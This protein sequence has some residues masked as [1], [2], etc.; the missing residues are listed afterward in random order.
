MR[1]PQSSIG[2]DAEIIIEKKRSEIS[3][4]LEVC[5]LN[6]RYLLHA[7]KAN[8]SCGALHIL[9]QKAF[10]YFSIR[11]RKIRKVL[12]LGFGAGSAASIICNDMGLDPHIT[13]IEADPVVIE[14]ARK[15]FQLEK[16]KNLTLVNARAQ[17]FVH[18]SKERFDLI[19]NDVFVEKEV[20]LEIKHEDYIESLVRMT[21]PHGIGFYN[22]IAED[23]IQAE[24]FERIKDCFSNQEINLYQRA[25]STSN[26]ILV[27]EKT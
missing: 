2:F 13:G 6:G 25:F 26:R 17:D 18:T 4:E 19:V 7:G 1:T 20:P 9:F 11:K 16:F 8:Y 10:K 21:A 27:W 14:L 5:S 3:G 15:Y 22:F 23:S 12:I 24:E